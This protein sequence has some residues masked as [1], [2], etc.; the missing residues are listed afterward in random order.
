MKEEHAFPSS[1]DS[2]YF[3]IK[4]FETKFVSVF[5]LYMN[6][7]SIIFI[8]RSSLFARVMA[9]FCTVDHII[10]AIDLI[11]SLSGP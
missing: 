11:W 2:F 7:E 1:L 9:S 3:S 4:L 10:Q 6:N 8:E 5:I